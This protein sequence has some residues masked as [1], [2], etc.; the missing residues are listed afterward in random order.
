[1]LV[2][3]HRYIGTD[4]VGFKCG[5]A[6]ETELEP[7]G[8]LICPTCQHLLM[9]EPHRVTMPYITLGVEGQRN[10]MREIATQLLLTSPISGE[11]ARGILNVLPKT[12][13]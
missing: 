3:Q 7:G 6:A 10:L 4:P 1:M 13:R 2:D 12:T 9:V 8:P 11:R 5:N